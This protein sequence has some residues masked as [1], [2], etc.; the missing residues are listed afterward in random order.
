MAYRCLDSLLV[1]R[2]GKE[3]ASHQEWADFLACLGKQNLA[4]LKV[5]IL[6][7]GGGPTASQRSELKLTMAGRSV[8]TAVVSDSMKVRFIIA[9]VALINREHYGFAKHELYDAY[10]F[11]ELT[12]D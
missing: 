2:Q 1:I 10:R 11:L 4:T 3:A 7:D 12:S 6:T 8:R 9:A 5:L